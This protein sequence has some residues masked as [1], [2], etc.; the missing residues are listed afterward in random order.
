MDN[1]NLFTS[2]YFIIKGKI[3]IFVSCK[4]KHLSCLEDDF[5]HFFNISTPLQLRC[6]IVFAEQG[7]QDGPF[8]QEC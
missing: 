6:G 4:D 3:P 8:G 5:T 7:S 2:I 1:T